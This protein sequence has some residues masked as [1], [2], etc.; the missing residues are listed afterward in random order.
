MHLVYQNRLSN[1]RINIP[2]NKKKNITPSLYQRYCV[3][4]S[5]RKTKKN[6]N[7]CNK[8]EPQLV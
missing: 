5:S 3:D 6:L 4:H 1:V 7:N 2:P 8:Y